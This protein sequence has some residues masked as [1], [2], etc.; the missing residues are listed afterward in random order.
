M[1][2]KNLRGLDQALNQQIALNRRTGGS[3]LKNIMKRP[4]RNSIMRKDW[5]QNETAKCDKC[6]NKAEFISVCNGVVE[7][8]LCRECYRQ[9]NKKPKKPIKSISYEEQMLKK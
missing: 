5:F 9:K 4:E 3:G 7:Y 6:G 2:T 1:K 8:Q